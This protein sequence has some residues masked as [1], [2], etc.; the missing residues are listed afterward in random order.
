MRAVRDLLQALEP[1]GD[2]LMRRGVKAQ[3]VTVKKEFLVL[4]RGRFIVVG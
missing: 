2:C 1:G 3:E 4:V